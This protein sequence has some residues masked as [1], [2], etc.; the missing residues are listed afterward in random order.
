M[1]KT[2]AKTVFKDHSKKVTAGIGMYQ[3]SGPNYH[4]YRDP[5][6]GRRGRIKRIDEVIL[7]IEAKKEEIIDQIFRQTGVVRPSSQDILGQSN[8]LF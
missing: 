1:D 7:H 4:N 8:L 6:A 5:K 2:Q 3:S